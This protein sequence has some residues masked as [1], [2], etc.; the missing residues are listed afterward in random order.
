MDSK[1]AERCRLSTAIIE[2]EQDLIW[3][4]EKIFARI[5]VPVSFVADDG[6][7]ALAMF[8]ECRPKP[9]IVLMDNRLPGM[10][11]IDVTKAII[12]SEPDTLVIF[13]S[14]DSGV[15]DEAIEAGA[16]RFLEKPAGIRD[17]I[18]AIESA[19]AFTATTEMPPDHW[20]QGEI[21]SL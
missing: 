16:F 14:G 13:L 21:G 10:N 15:R 4:Y 6:I 1:C 11:G 5:G 17:I 19:L 8:K 2:D 3:I 20:T 12:K 18:E 9:Q 7:D